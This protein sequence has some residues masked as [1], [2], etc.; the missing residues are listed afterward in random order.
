MKQLLVSIDRHDDMCRVRFRG[1]VDSSTVGYFRSALEKC[2][3]SIVIDC[4]ELTFIDASGL[5]LLME[6]FDH[7]RS[8]QLQHIP[9][10]FERLIH[11]IGMSKLFGPHL[12]SNV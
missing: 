6:V 8:V 7:N 11:T 4:S 1:E 9:P 5:I 12:A 3:G 10:V 2:H